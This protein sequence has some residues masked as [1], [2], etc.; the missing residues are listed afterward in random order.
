M[1]S[2]WWHPVMSTDTTSSISWLTWRVLLCAIWILM[3]TVLS[4]TLI[5]KYEGF[6]KSKPGTATDQQEATGS[7]HDDDTWRPCLKGVHPAWLLALRFFAFLVLL[8]MLVVSIV[9]DGG[10]IFYYYTE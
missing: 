6:W 8:S 7:L 1:R 10:S 5:W 9:I 2:D 3:C 4:L